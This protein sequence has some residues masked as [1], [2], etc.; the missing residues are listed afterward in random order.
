LQGALD[1][2]IEWTEKWGMAFN[3]SKCKVM[4]LGNGNPGHNYTMGGR[5]LETT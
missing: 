1:S 5:A 3:I 2:L 4:H